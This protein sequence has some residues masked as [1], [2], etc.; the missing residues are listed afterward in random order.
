MPPQ[1][2]SR[3]RT[4]HTTGQFTYA[5]W[6]EHPVPGKTEPT[7]EPGADPSAKTETE[8]ESEAGVA[9]A[10][11][12]LARASVTNSFSG[13]IEAAATTC[14]Y[15]IA[16]VSEE[17][18]GSFSGMQLLAGRLDGRQG[19]FVVEERGSFTADGVVHCAFEVV[20]G[21]GTGALTGL[22]GS[23]SYT[24]R[25]GEQSVPYAFAYELG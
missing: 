10:G 24:A 16:Y 18:S 5:D 4:L 12:R 1:T 3:T 25:H 14:E 7:A 22:R 19:T 13:G 11:P 9:G 23:G 2:Q 21:S 6:Q 17:G 15:T 8:R 20:A